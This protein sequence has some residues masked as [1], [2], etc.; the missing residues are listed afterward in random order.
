[1]LKEF[2]DA[3]RSAAELVANVDR[4]VR[5][6][7][8]RVAGREERYSEK[9]V[10][11][12]DERLDGFADGG[13]SW[14]VATHVSDKQSGQETATGADLFVSVT[15]DFRGLYVQ[16]GFQAQAK[17]NKNKKFGLTVDPKPRLLGQCE[18]MLSNSDSSFVFAYGE[19]DTKILSARSVLEAGDNSLTTLKT[20]RTD[21]FYY[22][23][24][25]CRTGDRNLYA[26]NEADL[27]SL[28]D[29]IHYGSAALISV[30]DGETAP[31]IRRRTR[32]RRS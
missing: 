18:T 15:M 27:Q 5:K 8:V 9:F 14:N 10:T 13:L 2:D 7:L 6:K 31:R 28:V 22:D 19:Q 12:L 23:F 26:E 25:I 3:M 16:K 17:I 30:S 1:M 21:D 24:F 32:K 20:Q 29:E 4:D 11:L